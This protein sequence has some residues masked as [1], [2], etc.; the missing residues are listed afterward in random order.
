MSGG[1]NKGGGGLCLVI[2][3]IVALIVIFGRGGGN[4][5]T[6]S[7]DA[8]QP[9]RSLDELKARYPR[10]PANGIRIPPESD[11]RNPNFDVGGHCLAEERA[12]RG[13]FEDCLEVVG[14]ELIA[15]GGPDRD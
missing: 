12:G 5:A 2:V 14:R 9:K 1:G 3:I 13:S 15:I 10:I 8:S 7:T 4:N 11:L 6:P